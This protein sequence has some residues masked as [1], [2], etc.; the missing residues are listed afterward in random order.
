MENP[1][2]LFSMQRGISV[3]GKKKH[4][5]RGGIPEVA[6][7]NKDIPCISNLNYL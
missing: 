4:L 3:L 5:V 1:I 6:L 7:F 2:L